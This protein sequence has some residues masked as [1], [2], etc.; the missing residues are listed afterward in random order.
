MKA[1][2]KYYITTPIYYPSGSWHLGTCYTTVACDCL[3]RFKRLQGYDVFYLTGTDEH[4]QKIE[5]NAKAAGVSPL[6]YVD[7]KVA[8]LKELWKLLG[9]SYDKFIRTTD[10][11]HR[12]SVQK[13]FVKLYESGDIYLGEYEGR[14]CAPCETFL[15]EA[16]L[17]DGKCPDCGREA[18]LTKEDAYFFRLSKYQDRII[19]YYENNP[20]FLEPKSRKNEMINNFLK[21]GLT[22]L[23]VTRTTVKWGI[24]V[25]F[26]EK[27]IIY[28][29][30]DAL[31]NY[32]TALGYPDADSELF[33][34]FWPADIHMVGKE[35]VRFHAI[36]WPALLMALGLPLPK[37]VYGHGW[38]TFSGDKIS[39]SKGNTVDPRLLCARYGVDAVRYFL[40]REIPFGQD[41]NYTNAIFLNRLNNDLANDLGNLISR[42]AAMIDQYTGGIVPAKPSAV[43]KE[44]KE[45][46]NAAEALFDR[47]TDAID[48]LQTPEALNEIIKLSQSCNKY[49][50]DTAPWVLNKSGD[51]ERLFAVLYN[52][53]ES[54]RIIA[55]L[56]KPFLPETA[57]KIAASFAAQSG[58]GIS[59]V[60]KFGKLKPGARITKIP[61][62]FPRI[63]IGKELAVLEEDSM[64]E[65][66]E[67]IKPKA[68]T[69]VKPEA[70]AEADGLI[71]IDEFAK[72]KLRTGR[73][74][75]CER[76]EKSEKLL[77][78][79][80]KMGAETRTIVS[81]IAGHYTP[82]Q[83]VGKNVIVA[84]NL[85]P[86]KLRGVMSEGMILCAE[87][88]EGRLSIA[89]PEDTDFADGSTV[90]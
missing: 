1:K 4:G 20:D 48:R 49:I 63:D 42:T 46:I 60:K 68:D 24:P 19:D 21:P 39:K 22:D 79:T 45:L 50:E 56:L 62:L 59:G 2:K 57:E 10:A 31:S 84:A 88:A 82:E 87:D 75:A 90:R 34:S 37:K 7:E 6:C 38:I 32:L 26:D 85:R 15:T 55:V 40:L 70:A 35:I 9:V 36:I 77:K 33:K 13:I 54:I 67:A 43:T 86:A 27:H 44:D 81:G 80:V 47:V 28:V 69:P 41:G 73:V 8:K 29:W 12:A 16:Q 51:S 5:N 14:Y 83:M 89:A 53:A 52:L 72:V 30:I 17:K 61:P 18:K 25:P 64:S 78:L 11:E 23:C 65:I 58:G 76:V 71:G 74:T 3:A 66:G